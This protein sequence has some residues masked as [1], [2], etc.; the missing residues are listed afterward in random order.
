MNIDE[1]IKKYKTMATK[2]N[3]IFSN[4]P[5]LAEK[6]NKQYEQIVEWLEELKWYR[7]MLKQCRSFTLFVEKQ[8][9]PIKT[10]GYT[11]ASCHHTELKCSECPV[12]ELLGEEFSKVI[13]RCYEDFYAAGF[14]AGSM[15]GR[16]EE[17]EHIKRKNH[18]ASEEAKREEFITGRKKHRSIIQR[19]MRKR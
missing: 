10:C 4:N 11:F 9:Q 12:T 16:Y 17:L 8:K 7:S 14:Y 18:E 15:A 2:G 3:A 13:V 19:F 6:S 5:D 1:A